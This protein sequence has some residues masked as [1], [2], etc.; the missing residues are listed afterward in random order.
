VP[1]GE[2]HGTELYSGVRYDD[3]ARSLGCH[4]EYVDSMADLAPAVERAM[5]SGLP[6]VMHVVVDPDLNADPIGYEQFRSARTY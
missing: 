4:G 2:I 3:L 1:E 6:A 5:A